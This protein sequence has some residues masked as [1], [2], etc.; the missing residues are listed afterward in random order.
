MAQRKINL[1]VNDVPVPTEGFTQ[2]FIERVIIGMLTELKGTGEIKDV[3]LS[4]KGNIVDINI[5][6]TSISVNP[7]I[8]K[9]IKNTVIGMVSSL[10]GVGQIDRLKISITE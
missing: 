10:K 2:E 7:F 9:F 3:Q 5:N 8:N 1:Y 6:N 4:I